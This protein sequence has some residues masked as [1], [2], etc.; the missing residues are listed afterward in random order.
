MLLWLSGTDNS[1]WDAERELRP[2]ADG[3]LHARSESRVYGARR[4]RAGAGA[5]GLSKRLER[6][7]PGELPLRQRAARPRFQ[8]DLR[9]AGQVR[10]ED[11]CRLCIHHRR[12]PSFFVPKLWSYFI[13]KPPSATTRAALERLY[14]STNYSDPP[15]RGRDPEAPRLL[16]G[17]THGQV[18]GRARRRN[19]ARTRPRRRHGRLGLDRRHVRSAPLLSAQ[20]RRLAGRALAGHG[21][22]SRPLACGESRARARIAKDPDA[23]QRLGTSRRRRQLVARAIAFWGSPTISAPTRGALVGFAQQAIADAD[24]SWKQEV[25]PRPDPERAPPA[26]PCLPRLPDQLRGS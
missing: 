3:A 16:Q 11:S 12:H 24:E 8:E 18:A 15:G 17:S 2:R 10:L 19:A 21:D 20:R 9:Q 22:V 13:P 1:R 6:L 26:H 23:E 25:Y 14:V 4:A 7:G 5:D